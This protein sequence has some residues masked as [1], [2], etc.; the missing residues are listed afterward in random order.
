MD[1]YDFIEKFVNE[2]ER[3]K[4]HVNLRAEGKRLY[5]YSTCIAEKAKDTNGEDIMLVS[6]NTFSMTTA[7]H[8]NILRNKCAQAG[9]RMVE[10]PQHYNSDEFYRSDVIE[11]I[12]KALSWCNKEGVSRMHERETII[13]NYNMLESTLTLAKFVVDSSHINELLDQYRDLYNQ[14]KEKERARIEKLRAKYN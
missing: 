11:K 13:K 4:K 1:N 5:S 9:I 10:L 14:A 7:R 6:D 2:K 8:L 3:Y 12:E